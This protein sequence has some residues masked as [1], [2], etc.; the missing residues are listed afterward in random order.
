MSL[1]DIIPENPNQPY[2]VK[3]VIYSMV[4]YGEFLEIHRH[5]ARN[6]VV[7]FAKFNGIPVVLSPISLIFWLVCSTLIHPG[8]QPGLCGFAM[9]LISR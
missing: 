9:L 1:N 5:Y 2:D 4:D 7:G 3:D 6:I 8:K